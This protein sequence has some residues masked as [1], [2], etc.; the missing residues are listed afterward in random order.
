MRAPRGAPEQR[1]AFWGK[2][3]KEEGAG[4]EGTCV[5]TGGEGAPSKSNTFAGALPTKGG[6]LCRL[7]RLLAAAAAAEGL[8][9]A[10]R[11]RRCSFEGRRRACAWAK[12]CAGRAV[13]AAGGAGVLRV[14]LHAYMHQQLLLQLLLQMQLLYAEASAAA[15]VLAAPVS[16]T[17]AAASAA[18]TRSRNRAAISSAFSYTSAAQGNEEQ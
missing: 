1:V 7:Q 3:G 11:L 5:K 17:R 4:E 15:S 14:R 12:N 10:R 16:S 13:R 18:A 6:T 8:L 2:E 9:L